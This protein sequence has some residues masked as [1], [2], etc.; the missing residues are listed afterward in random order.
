MSINTTITFVQSKST[1][2]SQNNQIQSV[3]GLGLK[4]IGSKSTLIDTPSVRGMFE[5]VKHLVKIIEE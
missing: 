5:K 4:G 1:I 2:G 3:K